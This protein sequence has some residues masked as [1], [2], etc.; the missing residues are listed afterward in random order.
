ME[1][2]TLK[3]VYLFFILLPV[4]FF[5]MSLNESPTTSIQTFDPVKDAGIDLCMTLGNHKNIVSRYHVGP[6]LAAVLIA[7]IYGGETALRL[8]RRKKSP[9]L[10]KPE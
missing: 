8:M 2:Y 3:R 10:S 5:L 9:N 1:E 6:A 4:C 7:L